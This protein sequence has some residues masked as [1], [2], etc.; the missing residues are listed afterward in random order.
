LSSAGSWASSA[1]IIPQ[2]DRD[3]LARGRRQRDR[4]QPRAPIGRQQPAAPVRQPVVSAKVTEIYEGTSEIQKL[5]IAR[6]LLGDA[7]RE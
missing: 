5:V 7:M 4:G 6:A 2:R 1:S 3:L